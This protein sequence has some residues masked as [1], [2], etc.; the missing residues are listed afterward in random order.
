MMVF[1]RRQSAQMIAQFHSPYRRGDGAL[2]PR[3]RTSA[4]TLVFDNNTPSTLHV[5]K[6]ADSERRL[7]IRLE[8]YWLSLR[9]CAQGAFFE[10]FRP[11]R[12]PVPWENCFLACFDELE[13]DPIFDHVGASIIVLLKPDRTNLP[14]TEWLKDTIASRFGNMRDALVTAKSIRQ[15][16]R[17]DRPGGIVALYR[18]LLLPFVDGKRVPRYVIGAVTYCLRSEVASQSDAGAKTM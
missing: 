13:A 15:E 16:G 2:E 1:G 10:D 9:W 7:T 6:F 3:P 8:D 4:V 11:T 17:L 12:N 18:S 5:A 14:D